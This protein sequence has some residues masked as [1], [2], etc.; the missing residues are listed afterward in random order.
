MAFEHYPFTDW[1]AAHTDRPINLT[2][3]GNKATDH[4]AYYLGA[5]RRDFSKPT[6]LRV[7]KVLDSGLIVYV[8]LISKKCAIISPICNCKIFPGR[9]R[10]VQQLVLP[11][12]ST[13]NTI[14]M[15]RLLDVWTHTQF[16]RDLPTDPKQMNSTS[17]NNNN[18]NK[19]V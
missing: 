19:N 6:F 7:Q 5:S 3:W 4:Y 1:S 10:L 17:N 18:N 14:K 8:F 16:K 12:K 15:C 13:R 11:R 9:G 2:G